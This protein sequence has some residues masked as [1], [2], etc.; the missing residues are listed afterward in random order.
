MRTGQ[1]RGVIGSFEHTKS[2]YV[3]H[4]VIV[5]EKIAFRS[6]TR[7][8]VQ[9]AFEKAVDAYMLA[10]AGRGMSGRTAQTA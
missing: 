7:D 3:G 5:D 8:Q 2:G 6:K 9:P 4:L 10:R 1:Y